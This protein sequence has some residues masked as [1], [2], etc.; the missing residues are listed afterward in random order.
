MPSQPSQPNHYDD[1]TRFHPLF[2]RWARRVRARLA[3]RHAL[4]GAAVGLLLA[5]AVAG[6]LWK[7]R[8]G[9]L[10]WFAPALG[11]VGAA[12]GLVMARRKRWSDTDVALYLDER[13]E[14]DEAITTA[15]EMRNESELDDPTRA[16]VVSN[17][18]SALAR[19]S[20]HAR[21]VHPVL[22]K[23]L[24]IA[25]PLALA[26]IVFVARAPLPRGPVAA[27][28]PGTTKVQLSQVD[29]LKKV[30]ELGK[31]NPRDDAQ[32]QRL[33]KLSKDA[34]KLK[35]DLEKGL[36]KREAQDRIAHLRDQIAAERLSLGEGEQRPGMEAAQSKLQENDMT[37]GAAK[38]LGDHD[39]EKFDQEMEKLANQREKADRETAKQ[40]LQEGA[41]AARANGAPGV[42]KA[43]EEEKKLMDERGKRADMLRDLKDAMKGSGLES[44]DLKQKSEALDR[45]GSDKDAQALSDAMGKALEKLTP[46]ERKRLAE[47]LKEK[48]KQ[49]GV[50]S[51]DAADMKDLADELS[52]PEGQK[53]LEDELKDM[54]KDDTESEESKRQKKLDDAENGAG[55][56]E[57]DIGK[58][59]P[60]QQGEGQPSEGQ[61]GQG[62]QGE[63]QQGQ[64]QQGEGQ[65]GGQGQQGQGQGHVP[66]P[67]PMEGAGSGGGKGGPSDQK[68]GGSG[69]P[70]SHHDTGAGSHG[71]KTDPVNAD[72]MK[73]RAHGPIN[74]GHAMPGSQTGTTP[75]KPGGTANT[76]GTGALKSAGPGEVDGVEHSDVPQE[77]RDQVRQYFNP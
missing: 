10:R 20:G 77:Y 32:K 76:K 55:D 67:V 27:K 63:G 24:H 44:D 35:A 17:A 51:G 69:P 59:G 38:A 73:S 34:D 30:V 23:P 66:I 60:G 31:I 52:T 26:A 57:K 5:I 2:E 46:E 21:R 56:A 54:A 14:T 42:A 8:H 64:G 15:V 22:W 13:L 71:G 53:K 40:K 74:K 68:G 1:V 28:A 18:A 11:I 45:S 48:A 39:L 12:V 58:Q 37:K 49:G 36:E 4:S 70:G 9:E 72:T 61:Q 25:V 3:L 41:D 47:K 29:G 65:Q 16:V 33:D 19:A 62:Q 7:T 50:G 43:L 75:G 6:A